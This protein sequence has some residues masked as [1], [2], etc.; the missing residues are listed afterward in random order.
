MSTPEGAPDGAKLETMHTGANHLAL[1][2]TVR[3][4]HT[5]ING[6]TQS[7]VSHDILLSKRLLCHR[8]DILASHSS[9]LWVL[10]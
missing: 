3:T 8:E 5:N 2:R 10:T 7:Y 1:E 9:A 6:S 4:V